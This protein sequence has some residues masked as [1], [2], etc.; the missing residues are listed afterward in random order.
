MVIVLSCKGMPRRRR[1]RN[2]IFS[3]FSIGF[4]ADQVPG[5]PREGQLMCLSK[6]LPMNR[7]RCLT[8]ATSLL[9]S[10]GHIFS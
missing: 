10:G 8:P 7:G 4:R 9:P 3:I 5:L 1:T 6:H 2:I